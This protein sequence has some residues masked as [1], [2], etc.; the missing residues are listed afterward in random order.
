MVPGSP[1]AG[2]LRPGDVIVR[3][4]G[5]QVGTPDDLRE[6]HGGREAGRRSEITYRRN[7][8]LTD[9]QPPDAGRPRTIP[10][11]PSSASS[12]SRQRRSSCRSRSTIDAGSIGGP[13]AGLAFALDIVDELGTDVDQGRRVVVD[14]RARARRRSRADRRHQAKGDRREAGRRRH[15]R[16]ARAE[17]PTRRASTQTG[18]RSCRSTPSSEALEALD[19]AACAELRLPTRPRREDAVGSRTSA[20]SRRIPSRISSTEGKL[21]ASRADSSPPPPAK[22][23][24]PLTTATPASSALAS[25]LPQSTPGREVEPEEVAALRV[26]PPRAL[27]KLASRALEH[28]VSARRAA[29]SQTDGEVRSRRGHDR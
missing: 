28:G 29:A 14:W 15:V 5:K 26:A 23:S 17:T 19:V 25:T 16:R 18:S 13:S 24:V 12:S 6:C 7:G 27:G 21:N 9:A 22:K 11:A 2:G 20:P 10:S 8:G 4:N 1:A 3:A